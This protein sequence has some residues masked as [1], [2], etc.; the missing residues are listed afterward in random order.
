MTEVE[1]KQLLRERDARIAE[2]DARIAEQDALILELRDQVA[3][4]QAL[5]LE[6]RAQINAN[7]SKSNRP[8]SS[9]GLKK[10]A[11]KSQRK[12]SGK[13]VGGQFGHPG[14]SLARSEPDMIV[15]HRP[16]PN[17]HACGQEL[18]EA[19]C[20]ESRQV[21]DMPPIQ[22][23]VTEHRMFEASC[24]CGAIGRSSWPAFVTSSVQYGARVRALAVYLTQHHML[25]FERCA[26]IL[27]DL[28]GASLSVATLQ[29]ACVQAAQE[30][31]P[32]VQEIGDAL[33][34]APVAH[35][36]ETGFRV[37][38]RL[39]WLHTVCNP[40]L[41]FIHAHPKRGYEAIEAGGV[42]P[43]FHGILIHDCWKAYWR[44][45]CKHGLCNAHLI[46]E[47]TSLDEDYKQKWAGKL[48]SVLLAAL[49][50]VKQN[51][52]TLPSERLK[53]YQHRASI[54]IGYGKRDNPPEM[55]QTRQG[56]CK[57]SVATNLLIRFEKYKDDIW[58][59]AFDPRVPFTN[60]CAEQAIRMPKVKQ[61]VSG[62]FRT[63]EGAQRFCIIRSYLDTMRKQGHNLLETLMGALQAI[64]L[65]PNY[66][67]VPG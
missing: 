31:A 11:P 38:K 32:V 8:P 14:S 4:L 13:N 49:G 55:R 64:P 50:E 59:F 26:A 56:K 45:K 21:V 65:H 67:T 1:W 3:M 17:C 37:A 18:P 52:G 34:V 9:D 19:T 57:Q 61:K 39:H 2:Q 42:L 60:N 58:R 63:L 29:Y 36:D 10:P 6:L 40:N 66:A 53:H 7:S 16:D 30:L 48:R 35:A 25:P 5:V 33:S 41:T 43:K 20:I 27:E 28:C 22:L 51:K 23:T 24:S 44:L 15:E 12:S 47:L 54:H 46:R 62:C